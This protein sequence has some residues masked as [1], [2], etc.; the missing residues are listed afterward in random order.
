MARGDGDLIKAP[1]KKEKFTT[2]QMAEIARCCDPVTGPG[3]FMSNFF[4]IQHPTQGQMLYQPFEYQIGLI[5]TYHSNRFAI[6]LM[7]RQSGKTTSAAGY[8]LWYSMF[9][10][11]ST[12][13]IA[14]HIGRGAMEIM[15]RI[16][17]GYE[18]CPDHIRAG[19]VS[20][21]KG[22]IDFDNG[23][24]IKSTT[25]TET[26]GRGMS[27]SLLYLDE[28]AFVR[29]TIAR[30]FWT[31]ISPTLATGGKCIITSTP[32]SDEDQFSL[33]WKGANKCLDEFG[34]PTH[35]GVNGFKAYQSHWWEHPERDE[36]WA[37]QMRAQLGDEKFDREIGC[38]F[39]IAEETLIDS[40]RLM[41]LESQEPLFRQGQVRWFKK[42]V[43][44]G[45][46]VIALDPAVGT[47][48]DYAAIQVFDAIKCEQI[49][50]WKHN[51]TR[52]PEQV[53]ILADICSY[54]HDTTGKVE[55]IYYSIEN[56][57]VGEATLIAINHY[58][59]ENI[60]GY[61]LSETGKVRKGFNTNRSSKSTAC[62]KLKNL[63]EKEK[64]TIYS[65]ALISELKNYIASANNSYAAKLG[66]H[67]DLVSAVLIAVRMMMALQSYNE[68]V[69]KSMRDYSDDEVVSPLPFISMTSSFNYF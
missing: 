49:A 59:E 9:V 32:N 21:N 68:E 46:Y 65:R 15:E 47:G 56:N 54:I 53:K 63:V 62:N 2:E 3:Y 45:V 48:G 43:R 66:E 42:P 14:A 7:P 57:T 22:S 50:E 55:D 31:A 19:V 38:Q 24:R 4:Y 67:D 11:D 41:L 13:L 39:I 28:F 23:S 1:H 25:T 44:G 37:T 34:N 52:T 20:Y 18:L 12:I 69:N 33:L 61:F 40:Q 8:L 16:R 51:K 10:P 17:Y 58:G 5:D 36:D 60:K 64:M 26:T 29:P 30:E 35:L 27:I 6:A